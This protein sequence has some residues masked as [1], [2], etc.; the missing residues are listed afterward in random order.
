VKLLLA[1]MIGLFAFPALA[2]QNC[3]PRDIVAG[4]LANQFGESRQ[5]IGL[6]SNRGNLMEVYASDANGTWTITVTLANGL[7]CLIGSGESFERL[8]ETLPPQ[9]EDM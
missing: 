9:G 1:C 5:A 8:A 7:T 4:R 3:A 2:Q 6:T